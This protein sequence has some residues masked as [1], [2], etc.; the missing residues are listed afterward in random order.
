M[1]TFLRA[2]LDLTRNVIGPEGVKAI[3]DALHVNGALTYLNLADN[4]IGGE[5]E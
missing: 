3:G 4:E 2:Q 1:T 5:G